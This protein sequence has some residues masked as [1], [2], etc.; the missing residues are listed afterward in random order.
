MMERIIEILKEDS[1]ATVKDIAIMLGMTEED[2]KKE[3]K[4]L[5]KNGVILKY[6]T[7]INEEKWETD[8][9][10]AFIEV[11]VNPER[12]RGFDAIA[13]RIYKFHQ[14]KS[15]YLMS[16]GFDFLIAV[17]GDSL[18]DVALFISEKLSSLDYVNSTSTHFLLKKYKENDIEMVVDKKNDNRIAVT[19]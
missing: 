3:I 10:K 4:R 12:E 9:V 2:V 1:R 13:E 6:T 11:K 18:K 7:I 17:E 14:V 8:K 5:E 16:G 19:P 15:L